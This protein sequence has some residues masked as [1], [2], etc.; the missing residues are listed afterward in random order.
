MK[1]KLDEIRA[2]LEAATPGKWKRFGVARHII[3]TKFNEAE[4]AG[5]IHHQWSHNTTDANADLIV[6][7]PTDLAYLLARVEAAE[8]REQA[9]VEAIKKIASN[10]SG[11]DWYHS[12]V[13]AR[14][15]LAANEAA[16]GGK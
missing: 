15:A 5:I 11:D 1:T 12:D 13:L 10:N 7:A 4:A 16:R 2:R 14:D 6:N 9:L 8:T 3:G